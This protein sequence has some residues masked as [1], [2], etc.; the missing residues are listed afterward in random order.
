MRILKILMAWA[1]MI[2]VSILFP[3][4]VIFFDYEMSLEYKNR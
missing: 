1:C 3:I 4:L 2:L